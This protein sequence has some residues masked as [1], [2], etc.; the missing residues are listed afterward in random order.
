MLSL[1]LL[2]VL[3]LRRD[4]RLDGRWQPRQKGCLLLC[5][6]ITIARED[7]TRRCCERVAHGELYHTHTMLQMMATV[8]TEAVAAEQALDSTSR[9]LFG[10]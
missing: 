2:L 4:R 7:A 10:E 6:T 1:L 3:V 9:R 5:T 8:A